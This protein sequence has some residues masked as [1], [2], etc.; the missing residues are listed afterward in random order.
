[1]ERMIAIEERL[2]T[3]PVVRGLGRALAWRFTVVGVKAP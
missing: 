1:M 2:A 3:T